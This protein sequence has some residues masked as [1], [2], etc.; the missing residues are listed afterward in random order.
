MFFF[1]TICRLC[2]YGVLFLTSFR[3]PKG[4]KNQKKI[5]APAS[6]GSDTTSHHIQ[7]AFHEVCLHL[8]FCFFCTNEH[9][10]NVRIWQQMTP[11]PPWII[12]LDYWPLSSEGF[13]LNWGHAYMFLLQRKTL[14]CRQ[15]KLQQWGGGWNESCRNFVFKSILL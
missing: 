1:V 12:G 4:E 14:M 6:W 11:P 2:C 3:F 13:L 5:N 10:I 9:C 7:M 8:F 15:N